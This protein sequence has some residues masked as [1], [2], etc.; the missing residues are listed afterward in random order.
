MEDTESVIDTDCLRELR[1]SQFE[2]V[3]IRKVLALFQ[4]SIRRISALEKYWIKR[5]YPVS[6]ASE[7][8]ENLAASIRQFN[9]G[10]R[11]LRRSNNPDVLRL[12]DDITGQ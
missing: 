10:L 8:A 7:L 3:E 5:G 6:G 12:R 2:M 4:S 11:D 9:K 1:D